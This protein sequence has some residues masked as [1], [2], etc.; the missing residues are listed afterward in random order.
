MKAKTVVQTD[1]TKRIVLDMSEL[2]ASVLYAM[3]GVISGQSDNSPR[4][5]TDN[6]YYELRPHLGK[7]DY[8]HGLSDKINAM[9]KNNWRVGVEDLSDKVRERIWNEIKAVFN[10]E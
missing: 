6:L 8:A 2:E 4:V 10:K 5:V 9:M 1:G 7:V 3:S